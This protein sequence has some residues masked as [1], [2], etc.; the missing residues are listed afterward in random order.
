MEQTRKLP[1]WLAFFTLICPVLDAIAAPMTTVTAGGDCGPGDF[2]SM[3][4]VTGV[5]LGV[6]RVSKKM[7]HHN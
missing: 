4:A 6:D 1:F 7:R 5:V 2:L 3:L